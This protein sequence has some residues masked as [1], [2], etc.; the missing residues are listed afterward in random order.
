MADPLLD[1]DAP[2]LPTPFGVVV[3]FTPDPLTGAPVLVLAPFA[4]DIPRPSISAF[5]DAFLAA[6]ATLDA[7][8]GFM[9]N[10]FAPGVGGGRNEEEGE[11]KG[12]AEAGSER[13]RRW[14]E[15]GWVE[16]CWICSCSGC[17]PTKNKEEE[18]VSMV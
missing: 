12:D 14:W 16:D 1:N 9:A 18:E 17:G 5:A 8:G 3:P 10:S 4:P 7:G 13:L 11:G 2:P 15:E 6:A